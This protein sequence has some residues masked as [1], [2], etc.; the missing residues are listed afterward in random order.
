[1]CFEVINEGDAAMRCSG[2]AHTANAQ[3]Y[4]Y[5]FTAGGVTV[6]PWSSS[7]TAGHRVIVMY[8]VS[9]SGIVTGLGLGHMAQCF[10]EPHFSLGLTGLNSLDSL[11][12][13]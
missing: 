13:T 12:V 1:M 10:V 2:G 8:L 5:V 11:N 6:M 7:G 9:G 4:S 3:G